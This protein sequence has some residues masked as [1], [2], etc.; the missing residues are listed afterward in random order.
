MISPTRQ[1]TV[2]GSN[3]ELFVSKKTTRLKSV[4][5]SSP[6]VTTHVFRYAMDEIIT[7]SQTA[8]VPTVAQVLH[9]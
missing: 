6:K 5:R 4:S 3:S 9:L 1:D 7:D 2:V 8:P